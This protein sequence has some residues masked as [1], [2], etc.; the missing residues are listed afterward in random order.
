MFSEI[1]CKK[2]NEIYRKRCNKFPELFEGTDE[3]IKEC[4]KEEQILLCYLY[5]NMPLSDVMNYPFKTFYDY[6]C[7]GVFLWKSGKFREEVNEELFCQYV[8]YHRINTESISPCRRFFYEKTKNELADGQTM[9]EAVLTLNYWCAQEVTYRASD[10]R[11]ASPITVYRSAHGR[12][13]EESTFAVSVLRSHGIP[14]R[15]V[16]VPRW[17]HCDDNHAWVEVW[18]NKSW[19]FFGACEPEEVLDR[20]WFLHAASRAMIIHSRWYGDLTLAG[21]E[22]A[23]QDIVSSQGIVTEINEIKSYAHAERVKVQVL[24]AEKKAAAGAKVRI[25]ILNYSQFYPIAELCTDERGIAEIDLGIGSFRAY[26]FWGDEEVSQ[27]VNVKDNRAVVL[28]LKT[29][30]AKSKDEV[31]KR[32]DA[33]KKVHEEFYVPEW[34][35]FENFAPQDDAIHTGFVTEEQ[36]KR[37]KE[38]LAKR[39]AIRLKKEGTGN[40]EE[41]E[42][43]LSAALDEKE[44]VNSDLADEKDFYRKRMLDVLT[45]KDLL[46][47]R[48]DILEAH[49]QH[50]WKYKDQYEE[51]HSQKVFVKYVLSPRIDYEMLTDYRSEID[52]L[53]IPE[54]KKNFRS[55]PINIWRYIESNIKE[56]S[57]EDY[58]ALL[59]L[60]V[61]CLTY[62]MGS[63]K[64]QNLLFVAICRTLGIPARLN[65]IDGGMEYLKEG[66]FVQVVKPDEVGC[67]K[68][69]AGSREHFV[70]LQNWSVTRKDC[71]ERKLL[72]LS[73]IPFQ[74]ITEIQLHSGRYELITANRLPNGNV[75]GRLTE[76]WIHP[77]VTTEVTLQME[78]V[79]LSQMLECV[80]LPHFPVESLEGEKLQLEDMLKGHAN[81]VVWLEEEQEP[82]EHILNE[83]CDRAQEFKKEK[84]VI[85]FL[86]NNEEALKRPTLHKTLTLLPDARVLCDN[87]QER[88]SELGRRLY[89]DPESIPLILVTDRDANCVYATSG[90]NV[91]TV[92]M[93]LKILYTYL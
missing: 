35:R 19:H 12:C 64:S 42:M 67:L 62:R 23:S 47:F 59:T 29:V 63:R 4:G 32:Y 51:P 75:M 36:R 45:E 54:Q 93:I 21:K 85:T 8:V 48:A 26:A 56:A 60:P 58:Q 81:L 6:A 11:T 79:R 61:S 16:Y 13:G 84:T 3:K 69:C 40:E 27:I 44:T 78:E 10:E 30:D 87:V 86:V 17:S 77:N 39:T 14:A 46:D 72:N 7:H 37:Q 50:A 66:R 71:S 1:F 5:G 88:V 18:C 89:V 82:S 2:I 9:L 74:K 20:G 49:L 65:P 15:Q 80:P 68:V 52:T 53:L 34:V 83:L 90:Y 73:Q 24:G 43:F 55:D 31:K 28:E 41:M 25:E 70:Y 91:G 33:L 92:D 22:V 57:K 76:I 38:K